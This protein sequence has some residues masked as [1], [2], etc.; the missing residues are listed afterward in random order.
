M[1]KLMNKDWDR[2]VRRLCDRHG[3]VAREGKK[4][5]KLYKDGRLVASVHKTVS[6]SRHA[7]ENFEHEVEKRI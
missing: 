1:P 6:D 2:A 3:L 5:V 7:L 4:G